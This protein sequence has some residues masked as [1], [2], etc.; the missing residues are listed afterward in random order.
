MLKVY[1][2]TITNV[3]L[4]PNSSNHKAMLPE[5]SKN[6]PRI[7]VSKIFQEYP[8]NIAILRKFFY[9]VKKLKN[10]FSGLSL[11][12]NFECI[13]HLVLVFLLLNLSM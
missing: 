8:Q 1:D 9:E 10:L 5:Y 2:F 7:S 11:I 4:L 6:N 13:S 3:D 12:V